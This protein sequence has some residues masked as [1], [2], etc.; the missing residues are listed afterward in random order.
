M[1][2]IS[3]IV[4]LCVCTII[5]IGV[6]KR[7]KP[8]YS[9]IV[10]VSC[11]VCVIL[12][13]VPKISEIFS[14]FKGSLLFDSDT[15]EGIKIFIKCIIICQICSAAKNYCRDA[16]NSFIAFCID[17]SEKAAIITASMPLIESVINTVKR[18]IGN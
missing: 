6:L 5:I 4:I 11:A 9:G 15:F 16:S 18:F 12:L 3:Q 8:E 7:F 14:F 2:E 17:L 13:A 1:K 10:S